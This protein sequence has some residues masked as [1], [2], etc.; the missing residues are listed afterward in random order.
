MSMFERHFPLLPEA[1]G[2]ER[3]MAEEAFGDAIRLLAQS[4]IASHV[5]A[6]RPSALFASQQRWLLSQAALALHF[7]AA[8]TGGPGVSRR[9]IGHL[10]V[11]HNIA[12]RNTAYAFFDEILKY[13]LV[14]P[15][16][17]GSRAGEVVPAPEALPV[18]GGW[19]EVHLAAL[20]C[21]DGGIGAAAS[22]AHPNGCFLFSRRL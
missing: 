14:V 3:L 21:I 13:G 7:R 2:I 16:P 22:A 15:A 10:A 6:P 5:A 4:F 18:L 12:S 1:S 19:Y 17:G 11:Q 20:D 9:A 8:E